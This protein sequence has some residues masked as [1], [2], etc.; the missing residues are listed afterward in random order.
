M[1][2]PRRLTAIWAFM[3]C[4]RDSFYQVWEDQMGGICSMLSHNLK[5]KDVYEDL[6]VDLRIIIKGILN[7]GME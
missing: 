2:K 3:T 6:I 5:E 4:Y 1:W 7:N